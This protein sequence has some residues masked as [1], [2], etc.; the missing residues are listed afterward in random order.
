MWENK[1]KDLSLSDANWCPSFIVKKLAEEIYVF[2]TMMYIIA[3]SKSIT[4]ISRFL[5]IVLLKSAIQSD[6]RSDQT[7]WT[8]H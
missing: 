8:I 4:S 3:T 5:W 1:Y 2:A 6:K 7:F